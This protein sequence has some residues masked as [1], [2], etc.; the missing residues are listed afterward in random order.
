MMSIDTNVL[1]A[2]VETGNPDHAKAAGFLNSLHDRVD[3]AISE[4]ALLELYVLLRNPAVLAKPLDG[5]KAAAVCEAFRSH[6]RW[7]VIGFPPESRAFHD[8]LW[9]RLREKQFAR[10]RSYDWRM[11][12]TLIRGGVREFATVN[13]KDFTG[14]GFEK[15][16][17][18]LA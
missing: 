17:N 11:A 10:R 12:L 16:W 3:V 4:F 14:L 5:E 15:V 8:E 1:L 13:V 2:A 7:Q 6:P 9:P 18:P